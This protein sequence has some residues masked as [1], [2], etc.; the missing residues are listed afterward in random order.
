MPPLDHS[1][2]Q[3][4]EDLITR[5]HGA[6]YCMPGSTEAQTRSHGRDEKKLRL[7]PLPSFQRCRSEEGSLSGG[8]DGLIQ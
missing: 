7:D 4:S 6:R 2:I 5:Q 8:A 1:L 3:S